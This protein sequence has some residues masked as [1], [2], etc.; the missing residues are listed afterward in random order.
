MLRGEVAWQTREGIEPDAYVQKVKRQP[1]FASDASQAAAAAPATPATTH[2]PAQS[3]A[4]DDLYTRLAN[5]MDWNR[6]AG[7]P[8]SSSRRPKRSYSSRQGL[9]T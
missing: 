7:C 3:Y 6:V 4:Q 9:R 2:A 8:T 1:F 5:L